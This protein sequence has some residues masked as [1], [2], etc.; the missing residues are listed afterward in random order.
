MSHILGTFKTSIQTAVDNR[1]SYNGL[2]KGKPRRDGQMTTVA[3]CISSRGNV[4]SARFDSQESRSPPR[5]ILPECEAPRRI[6]QAH[7]AYPQCLVEQETGLILPEQLQEQSTG[8]ILANDT[9]RHHSPHA[10]PSVLRH[11]EFRPLILPQTGYSKGSPFLR[12]YSKDLQNYGI[13]NTEFQQIVDAINIAIVPN[14][15]AQLFQKVA[16][17]AGWFVPGFGVLGVVAGQVG[18]GMASAYGRKSAVSRVLA[19]ANIDV[20]VPRGLE[21]WIG[22]T[23]NVDEDLGLPERV[24]GAANSNALSPWELLSSYNGR[25]A[26]IA[27]ASEG[28]KSRG[29]TDPIALL[30]HRLNSS[31]SK[32]K[33]KEAQRQYSDGNTK[34]IEQLK[35]KL[36]WLI[37][38]QASNETI[39]AWQEI[40]KCPPPN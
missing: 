20:F 10:D 22:T 29:R 8:V 23:Q 28:G 1:K 36:N 37:I 33:F 13:S 31:K 25:V 14:P 34:Q 39:K 30:G 7:S 26:P 38:T 32:E 17:V 19:K 6:E 3:L 4:Q 5:Q 24:S 9:S 11:Y 40:L 12:G 16:S 2:T 15:E 18:V 35:R 27:E 21:I